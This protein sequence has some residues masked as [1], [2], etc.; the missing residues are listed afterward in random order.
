[1]SLISVIG[2]GITNLIK[3]ATAGKAALASGFVASGIPKVGTVSVGGSQAATSPV[4]AVK[5]FKF[6]Y[7]NP[8]HLVGGILAAGIALFTLYK[9][10]GK[11]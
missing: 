10:F 6:D 4:D 1:M 8:V 7:T 11:R 5:S 9:I 3:N 2:T